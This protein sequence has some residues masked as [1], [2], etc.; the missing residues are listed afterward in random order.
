MISVKPV[1]N[2]INTLDVYFVDFAATPNAV[3]MTIKPGSANQVYYGRKERKKEG[4][5]LFNDALNT[6]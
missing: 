1:K 6:F 5:V 3:E 2:V 4:N